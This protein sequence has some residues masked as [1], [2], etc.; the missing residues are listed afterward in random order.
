MAFFSIRN[1]GNFGNM[2]L[3]NVN[4]M[5]I[6]WHFACYTIVMGDT[7]FSTSAG[8]IHFPTQSRKPARGAST[9]ETPTMASESRNT[10][11]HYLRL[12]PAIQQSQ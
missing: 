4:L 3:A 9:R 8:D 2:P 1:S 12:N 6:E 5:A 7:R 10:V 11:G